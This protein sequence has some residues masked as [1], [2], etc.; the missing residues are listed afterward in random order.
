MKKLLL[1]TILCGLG[2]LYSL[3]AM[4]GVEVGISIALPPPLVF[5]A[6]PEVVVIPETYVY[7]VPDLDVDIYFHNGWWWRPWQGRWYRSQHY[8][9]GWSHYRDVPTFYR[10][11]PSGWRTNYKERRWKGHQWHFQRIPHHEVQRNW[12]DW[13][14]NR[15]WEKQNSWGVKGLPPRTYSHPQSRDVQPQHRDEHRQSKPRHEKPDKKKD[16]KQDK[17][18]RHDRE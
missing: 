17:D 4:A 3:P 18:E 11:I 1:G 12:N 13:E 15:H 2:I 9:S 5:A 8:D 7:A 14:K 16:N 10:E 6:P